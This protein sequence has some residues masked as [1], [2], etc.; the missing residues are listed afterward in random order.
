VTS[1]DTDRLTEFYRAFSSSA[2]ELLTF[3]RTAGVDVD[4]V[5]ARDLYTRDL[6]CHNLG[7]YRML[8]VI[9]DIAADYGAPTAHQTVLDLGCGVGGPGRFLVD[10]FGCSVVGVD[11]LP[12]RVEIAEA[13]TATTG[14]SD[15]ISYRVDEATS[16][17][18]DDASFNQVWMLDV[19]MHIRAKRALFGE[20]ARVLEPGGLLVMHD[21][22]GPLPSAMRPVM[23]MAPYIAP[24]L[25]Q[26]V[27]YVE[28]SGMRMLTWR[29][30][31]DRVVEY[32][33]GMRALL[34]QAARA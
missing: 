32:F 3:L 26:L 10:H 25:P 2:D 6:D 17:S 33:V 21:Q 30:T 16:L 29:D 15:R 19:S 11:L 18:L 7:M 12:L 34:D 31:T 20:I 9:A 22:T 5:E 8:E 1:G 28:D 14:L 13:L 23:R 27:R 4:H 24:P